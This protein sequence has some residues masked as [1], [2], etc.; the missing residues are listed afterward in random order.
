MPRQVSHS[1]MRSAQS[2]LILCTWIAAHPHYLVVADA[3]LQ[4]RLSASDSPF[5]SVIKLPPAKPGVYLC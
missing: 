1:N 2:E 3:S 5:R 4:I